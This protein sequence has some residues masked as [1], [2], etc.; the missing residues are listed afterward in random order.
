MTDISLRMD[1]EV[2]A[3]IETVSEPMKEAS[4]SNFDEY[5]CVFCCD[6]LWAEYCEGR[7]YIVRCA[8]DHIFW[9]SASSPEDAL[10]S[11]ALACSAPAH[12]LYDLMLLMQKKAN[13][14]DRA[15]G[16]SSAAKSL[17][18]TKAAT[19]IWESMLHRLH[20][21]PGE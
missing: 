18:F 8:Q 20:M 11:V 5:R 1:P 13:E 9:V 2:H 3:A 19:Y 4:L 17:A 6:P 14:F 7:R 12:A 15:P 21:R 10:E 16:N